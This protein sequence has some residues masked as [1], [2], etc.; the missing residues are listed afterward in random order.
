M[1]AEYTHICPQCGKT[2]T[3]EDPRRHFCSRTCSGRYNRQGAR[4]HW[5]TVICAMCGKEF[6]RRPIALA[7]SD[8]HF[9]TK[10]CSGQWHRG[11]AHP[12][13][14]GGRYLSSGGYVLVR[15]NG[16]PEFEHRLTWVVSHGPIPEGYEIHHINGD[17]TDNRL[18]NLRLV[19][20]E[21]HINLH[22]PK[23]WSKGHLCCLHCGTA[24]RPHFALGYCRRC[25]E[26]QSSHRS[27]PQ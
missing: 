21:E 4:D 2:F 12:S 23:Q 16:R 6:Q 14:Q 26:A 24:K 22:R 11:E 17:K 25:Y 20:H 1:R 19:T 8:R 7:Q 10:L 13:W 15:S 5:P 9:C 3:A 27:S 18:T